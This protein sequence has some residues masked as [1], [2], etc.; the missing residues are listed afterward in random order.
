MT[1]RRLRLGVAGLGRAFMLMLPALAGHP[2]VQLVAAADPRAESRARFA[3]DFAAR[4]Y[5]SVEALCADSGIEAVYIAT[6]HQ[7]HAEHVAIAAAH[8][9]H[10]LVE[11][12][13]A[14]TLADCRAMCEAVNRAGVAM[15]IGHSHSFDAP[16]ARTRELIA[17]GDYGRL[18]MITAMNF[19]DFLYRPRRPEELRNDSGGGVV[20]NQAPHHVDVVRLLAGGRVKSVR[21]MTGA[22]DGMR[23]ADGAYSALLSFENGA[24]A[25]IVYS[26]YAH[27]DSDEFMGWIAESGYPK[28]PGDYGAARALL[29]QARAPEEEIALKAA[30]NYGGEDAPTAPSARRWHQQFGVLIASCEKADLRPLPNGVA[31]YGDFAKHFEPLPEPAVPRKEVIAE[32]YDAVVH[33]RPGIHTG[34][35]GM[36]TMEVCLA[37]LQSAREQREIVLHHQ[38]S[39]P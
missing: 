30:R 29:R 36:A 23:P 7:F 37:M 38:V 25:S 18:R 24:F 39:V 32:L 20:F 4:G 27:F 3:A 8:G 22:W 2:N 26:G 31:I 15:V 6:P 12:P 19:T 34:E 16:I 17:S 33:G 35:W 14:L 21:A 11:K 9:K 10:V 13:M 28:D 1:E 5:D